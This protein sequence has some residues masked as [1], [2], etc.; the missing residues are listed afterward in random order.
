MSRSHILLLICPCSGSYILCTPFVLMHPEQWLNIGHF[1]TCRFILWEGLRPS[2]SS[3]EFNSS[4][5]FVLPP[6]LPS[7]DQCVRVSGI[8]GWPPSSSVTEDDLELLMILLPLPANCWDY[9]GVNLC[10]EYVCV[11]ARNQL[12]VSFLITVYLFCVCQ[13]P[14]LNL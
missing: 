3:L 7:S 8:L 13:S 5:S 1:G 12:R 6:A 11:E 2:H 4:P 9:R 14:S 10:M